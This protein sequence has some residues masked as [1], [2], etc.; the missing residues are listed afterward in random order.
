MCVKQVQPEFCKKIFLN[1]A[2]KFLGGEL[3]VEL[4]T[5]Q[6]DLTD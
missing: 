1:F 5:I 6:K 2:R 4:L 3:D